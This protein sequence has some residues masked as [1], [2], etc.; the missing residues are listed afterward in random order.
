MDHA[1]RNID[2]V[3]LA[4]DVGLSVDRKRTLA[5]LDDV[6][7]V[8]GGV[9]MPLAARSAGQQSVEMHVELISAEAWIDQLDLLASS[10]RH[11]TDRAF[12]QMQDF[13]HARSPLAVPV[14][15]FTVENAWMAVLAAA[16][17]D[18]QYPRDRNGPCDQLKRRAVVARG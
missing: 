7:V 10:S 5:A 3:V 17:V 2:H 1:G 13:E 4:D 8:G 16:S 15:R 12:V 9:V 6:D 11:R 18:M 14:T